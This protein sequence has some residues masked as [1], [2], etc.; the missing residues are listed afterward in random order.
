MPELGWIIAV[1]ALV[2]LIVLGLLLRRRTA[3]GI[4]ER[5]TWERRSKD[6]VASA[7]ATAQAAASAVEERA[8]EALED[9][10]RRRGEMEAVLAGQRQ[11]LREA[12]AA[13]ERRESRLHEREDRLSAEAEGLV[14]RAER[15]DA[16]RIQLREQ[17]EELQ[18]QEERLALELERVAR[19]SV[20]EARKEVLAAAEKQAKLTATSI[21]RDIEATAKREADQIA[22]RV[23]TTAIQR[24]AS[25]QTSESVVSTV[26]LPS[27]DMKG[28]I[29]GR[30]GRNIRAFEQITGVNVLIDDTPESVL[31]SSF[32]PVRRET[33]RLT[34][35]DLI[36][37]GRIH[38]ARIE[39]VHERS[40]R[41]I[42]DR[43]LRAGEDALAEVGIV[44]LH[45]DLV[46]IVGALAFRTSYGQNVL[47][48]LV[49]CAHL[50]GVMAAE[51]GLNVTVCKRA[52]F[53]HDIGKALTHEVEGPHAIIGAELLRKYGEH[54]DIA[55]AVEAH[56]NEVE[57]RTV[58]A[59]L[60]Q[61]ADAISGSRPGARRESLEAYVERMENLEHIATKHEGVVRAYAMQ[62]GREVRVMVSPDHVDDAG[63]HAL[64]RDIA[65]EVE[66]TLSYPGQIRI[67]VV[68]ESRATET[69]H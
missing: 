61:A 65:A 45:P 56:H 54:E 34:L 14:A 49:E 66:K 29:I 53:L 5:L 31:L 33:A 59:V 60:T 37:D 57:P 11:E 21:A 38:P 18:A 22:R 6:D 52:A 62:A 50:A 35:V 40:L 64:A 12:R 30:E 58:E 26:D 44:D 36:A 9:A 10:E 47:R 32:D 7:R 24:V 43:V 63:A 16:Q 51:L 20:E 8:R 15:L 2:G 3:E 1:A 4:A 27:D 55:H 68:R 48:H 19:L 23:I 69:A 25:E 39:E 46:P 42:N 41:R 28:R 13:Q 17:R 67:T